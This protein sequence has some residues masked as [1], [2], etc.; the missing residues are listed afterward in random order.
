ML[1]PGLVSHLEQAL[2]EALNKTIQIQQI[3]ASS[4]GCINQAYRLQTT[5]S[6]WFVK[7]NSADRVDMFAA[8][9]DGL[10][11]LS[12]AQAFRV[13]QPILHGRFESSSYLV[14][15]YLTLQNRV[16]EAGFANALRQL[17]SIHGDNFGYHRDNYIGTSPQQNTPHDDW[18]E[19]FMQQRL[20]PQLKMLI[21]SGQGQALMSLWHDFSRAVERLFANYR[22]AKSLLHGDLWQGNVGQSDSKPSIYDPAC[23]YGDAETDLAML[24]LFG[25]PTATFYAVYDQGQE[26]PAGRNRRQHVYN[27][28]HVL[29]HANLFGGGY[30]NQ[31][32][33]MMRDIISAINA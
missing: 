17:H 11:S 25:R 28:Y 9:A 13:P 7:C 22:P 18:F 1:Q 21:D 12:R 24:T 27:L 31:A 15:E 14:M 26:K 10:N 4:G 30:L 2:S 8:E 5:E 29:N 23:Y 19:F 33:Q 3:S 16:D 20:E 6:D 32:K